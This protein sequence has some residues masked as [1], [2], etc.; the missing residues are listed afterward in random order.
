MVSGTGGHAKIDSV[1][2]LSVVGEL[3]ARQSGRGVWHPLDA[4][5][6]SLTA[7]PSHSSISRA[8]LV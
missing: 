6:H 1:L 8:Q 7:A 2:E 3:Q 4:G 5:E